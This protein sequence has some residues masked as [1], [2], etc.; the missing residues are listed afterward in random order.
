MH[1]IVSQDYGSLL[2]G[3]HALFPRETS[4]G[5]YL[6]ATGGRPVYCYAISFQ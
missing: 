6:T 5:V 1:T 3:S 2:W 4:S